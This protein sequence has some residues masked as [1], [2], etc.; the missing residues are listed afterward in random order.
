MTIDKLFLKCEYIADKY[1]TNMLSVLDI[2]TTIER[3]E[4][5]SGKP[6]DFKTISEYTERYFKELSE[7][8]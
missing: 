7:L 8:I 4:K 2:Y 3:T 1:E 6:Y 5:L